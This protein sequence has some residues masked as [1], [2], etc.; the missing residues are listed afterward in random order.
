MNNSK[1][2]GDLVGQIAGFT[3]L[4][5]ADLLQLSLLK[6]IFTII[7]P[8]EVSLVTVDANNQIQNKIDYAA[9]RH[10]SESSAE[11]GSEPFRLACEQIDQSGLEYCTVTYGQGSLS[12]FLVEQNR[13]SAQFVSIISMSASTPKPQVQQIIGMLKIYQNFRQLLKESQTDE[14]TG[15][16]N[17]KS[18]DDTARKIHETIIPKSE[19][20]EN[21]RR[22]F[23]SS[24]P[25]WLALVDIDFF[26]RVND[27]QGHLIGDEVLVRIAQT[28]RASFRTEDYVFR[29]GGEEFAIILHSATYEDTAKII[30][31]ARA[32]IERIPFSGL[33]TMTISVGVAELVPGS[34]YLEN[35]EEAD[36]A[37]YHS[38][39]NGRNQV[40]FYQA[41]QEKYVKTNH[42]GSESEVDL[43]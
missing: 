16:L 20:F 35:V 37:L 24:S 31:R 41:I 6:S 39:E 17:R 13:R 33:S 12:L 27:T 30:E 4:R 28:L 25:Y 7:S 11:L 22:A 23:D 1:Y 9:S 5:D 29:Y 8:I 10:G 18:F 3:S 14:L 2:Q 34:F 26:K 43:F 21:E 15:L 40:T 32:S 19:K 42:S 38:K 36:R